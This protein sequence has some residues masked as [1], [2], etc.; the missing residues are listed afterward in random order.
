MLRISDPQETEANLVLS[1]KDRLVNLVKR[2]LAFL[3]YG[4][5]RCLLIFGVTGTRRETK[6]VRREIQATCRTFGGLPVGAI[7]GNIWRKS[8]FHTPYLRNTLW[9]GGVAIDTLETAL[10]W[11]RLVPA[12]RAIK[13]ALST[14]SANHGERVFVFAHLSHLYRDGASIYITYAFRRHKDPD[15]LLEHW[16]NMKAAASEAIISH[17]GTISHQHGVGVDHA[18]YLEAEKGSLGMKALEAARRAFDP[19]ALLNP[20]KLLIP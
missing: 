20:G 16:M 9:E 17:G 10:P 4:P 6:R 7:I 8:R 11:T 3:G 14:A 19:E 5:Q 12:S 18:Q 13:E 15:Y 1:G 2:G